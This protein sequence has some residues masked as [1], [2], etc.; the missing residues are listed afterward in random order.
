MSSPTLQRKTEKL[1]DSDKEAEI[2][3]TVRVR[4]QKK[5]GMKVGTR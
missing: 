4:L 3:T 5:P 2:W 1:R